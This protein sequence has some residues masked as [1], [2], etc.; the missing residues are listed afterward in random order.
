MARMIR[1][2]ET[3]PH[4]IDPQ[5]KPVFICMCGLSKNTPFCDGSH[6]TC[7]NEQAGKLYIYNHDRTTVEREESDHHTGGE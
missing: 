1:H 4:R 3:A 7:K 2:H 6:S 5:E